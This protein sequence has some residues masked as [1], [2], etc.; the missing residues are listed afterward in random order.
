VKIS[1]ENKIMFGFGVA[2]LVLGFIS[3]AS[4]WSTTHLIQATGRVAHL[5]EI[6]DELDDVPLQLALAEVA[7]RTYLLSGDE[8]FLTAYHAAETAI[9]KEIAD[10]RKLIADSP[11]RQQQLGAVEFRVS[12][13]FRTLQWTLDL[14]KNQGLKAAAGDL[15]VKKSENIETDV[16]NLIR[17]IETDEQNLLQHQLKH[18]DHSAVHALTAIIVSSSLAIG[19][20]ILAGA[21]VRRDLRRRQRAEAAL[22]ASEERYRNLVETARD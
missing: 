15:I 21:L 1:T 16:Q 11:T 9:K 3:A 13:G 19:M 10:V 5:W 22:H 4:Y 14:R 12:E 2:S 6:L 7:Q 17:M 18:T 20:V 8:R